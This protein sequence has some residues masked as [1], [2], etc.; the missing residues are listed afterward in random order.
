MKVGATLD[1][2][3][4]AAVDRYV[5]AHPD[6]DRSTVIDEALRL[7]YAR[8]QDFAMERQFAAPRSSRELAEAEDWRRIRHAAAERM[9][10]RMSRGRGR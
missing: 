5:G 7:W 9:I 1:P 4:V 6:I 3:L 8:Q 2:E 10:K